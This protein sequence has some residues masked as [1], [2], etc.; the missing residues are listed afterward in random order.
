VTC[1]ET[2][3]LD[4]SAR[5]L[6]QSALR[7]AECLSA[8]TAEQ[9]WARANPN[10]NAVGNLT[11][12]LAGNIRQWLIGGVGGVPDIRQRD[13]EF[14]T[15]TGLSGKELE[16]I[17]TGILQEAVATLSALPPARLTE[18]VEIQGFRLTVL[19]AIYHA[20]EHFSGHTHQIILLAK[21]HRDRPFE[22]YSY[23]ADPHESETP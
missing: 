10:S 19:E 20:V 12:H 6:K 21:A 22:F 17:L 23:L 16:L 8:L 1:S 2:I 3:F 7:I 5:K 14:A 18:T 11:L 15:R 4:F 13:V 9:L